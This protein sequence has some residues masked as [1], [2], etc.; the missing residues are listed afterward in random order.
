MRVLGSV[1]RLRK[2]RC[3]IMDKK[4]ARKQKVRDSFIAAAGEI[5]EHEGVEGLTIRKVADI[6][7]YNSATIYNYFEDV[8]ELIWHAVIQLMNKYSSNYL[9]KFEEEK[10]PLEGYLKVW[11]TFCIFCIDHPHISRFLLYENLSNQDIQ[12]LT[13]DSPVYKIERTAL[14]N[15]IDSNLIP[16]DKATYISD[17]FIFLLTGGVS[18]YINNRTKYSRQEIITLVTGSMR[19]FLKAIAVDKAARE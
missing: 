11:E 18:R 12:L 13:K 9:N 2:L 10:D 15:C 17:I 7:Q 14:Q 5:L 4:S 8:N 19:T 6:A 3:Y 1:K 16:A